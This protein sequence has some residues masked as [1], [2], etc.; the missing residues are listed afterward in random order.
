MPDTSQYKLCAAIDF[1]TTYSGLAY[2]YAYEK[3]KVHILSE[4]PGGV[5]NKI[6]TAVLFD[7]HKSLIAFGEDA[8][9][10]YC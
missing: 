8:L 6:P 10:K 5:S 7:K 4:W 9:T 1:G 3:E 2:S